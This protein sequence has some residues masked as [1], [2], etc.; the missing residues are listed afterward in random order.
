MTDTATAH[1]YGLMLVKGYEADAKAALLLR[2]YEG[3]TLAETLADEDP[4]GRMADDIRGSF[5]A[6]RDLLELGPIED[7]EDIADGL[8]D[9]RILGDPLEVRVE[10]Y[11]DGYSCEWVPE[12]VRI[13]VTLGGP[14]AFVF[15]DGGSTWL[16]CHWGGDSWDA[17]IFGEAADM[18]AADFGDL[19]Y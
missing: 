5:D 16:E 4:A 14:N 6:A 11:K 9:W 12:R 8:D 13:A 10:G 19:L 18:I 15:T 17:P 7:D 3:M 1:A 2:E